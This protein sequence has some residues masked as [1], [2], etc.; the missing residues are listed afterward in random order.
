MRELDYNL[1]LATCF[2]STSEA[3]NISSVRKVAISLVSYI[4][5]R[6]LSY[7]ALQIILFGENEI[8]KASRPLCLGLSRNGYG[9]G[10]G[11][12]PG[13]TGSESSRDHLALK[14]NRRLGGSGR[15]MGVYYGDAKGRR[16]G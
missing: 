16:D 8:S 5:E 15:V 9:H 2:G 4:T 10:K 14:E 6:V 12:M 3:S 13:P 7:T 11:E 1:H